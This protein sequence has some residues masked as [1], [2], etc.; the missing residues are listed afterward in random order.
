MKFGNP[1]NLKEIWR[2]TRETAEQAAR[3]AAISLEGWLNSMIIQPAELAGVQSTADNDFHGNDIVAEKQQIYNVVQRL[4]RPT[5]TGPATYAPKRSR[6]EASAPLAGALVP[7]P[8]QGMSSVRLPPSFEHAV[9]EIVAR[10]RVLNGRAAPVPQ[11]Q[12]PEY[13]AAAPPPQHLSGLED[14]L[15]KITAQIETLRKPNGDA[16][17]HL[18]HR[19]AVLSDT[20]AAIR[21]QFDGGEYPSRSPASE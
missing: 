3:R 13:F 2:E 20:L 7:P 9:A 12:L 15:R 5:R 19:I 18:E 6:G 10:Q 1:G 21:V 8:H 14:Q 17:S 4:G 11:Q 16:F